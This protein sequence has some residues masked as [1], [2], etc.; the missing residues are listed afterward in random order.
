MKKRM[1]AVVLALCLC[2]SSQSVVYAWQEDT[3]QQGDVLAVESTS[4]LVTRD[5]TIPAPTEVYE[6]MIALKD[7]DG[8]KEGTAWTNDEPYSDSKGY[9]HWKGG[10]LDGKNISAVGCVAFA[11]ILSDEAFGSLPARMYAAGAFKFE[12]IKVGDILRVN[13]DAHT[14]IVL[15]VSEAGVVV[16]EGNISTGDHKGKVH[17]GRAIS[18]E[19]VLSNTSH[20]ITR[21]PE[22]Y[23]PPNDP[24]AN[25]SIAA[26]TLDG[27]LAWN[28]T[29]AGTLTISGKGAMPD[30]SSTEEQP[31]NNNSGKI[32]KVVIGDGVT[33]IGSCAF[34]NCGILSVAISPS[35]STIGNSAF[36]SSSI[37]SVTIPSSVKTIGDSAF[38]ECKNL[39]SVTVSEGVETIAQ[40]AFR[41]CASLTSIALPASIG[42]VGAATF[43]QCQA[44][45][46]VTFAPGSKQVKLGDNMFT[47][48]YYLMGVTLPKSIDCIGEGMF[49]NCL[50]L[51]GVEIPQ[52]AESIGASAFASCSGLTAVIIPDSVTTIGI[53]AFSSCPLTDI[54]FTGTE[55][56]W[57]SI[58]KLGDTVAAVSKATIHYN[59]TPPTK[60]DPDD[61]DNPGNGVSISEATVTLSQTSYTYD[62]KAKTPSVTVKLDGK[63][64]VLN[65]D[66]TISYSNNIQVGTATVTITGKG[67]YTGSKTASFTITKAPEDTQKADISKA[68]LALD[69]TSYTYDGKAKTPSV[70]VKLDGK[71]LV[72]NTDYTVSYSNNIQVGTATVTITGKGNY[73]G[74]K[75]A[76]FTITKAPNPNP[77]PSITCNKTLYKVAYGTKPFKINASSKSKM[78]F[79]SSK[80]KIA[81]VN[82]NTGKVTIK[83]T[84]VATITIKAGKVSKKVT[85][86]V[87]PKKQS[88]KSVKVVK[89]KKLT[90]KWAKDK[91]A[92]GYQVQISTDKKFKKNMKSKNL[93]KTSYT[94]TKLKT[95][96][97][98][99][100]RM[101]SYKKSGKETLYGTWSKV[102]LSSKIKK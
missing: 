24:E 26:G 72:L 90:V 41:A 59:Y 52:G 66:Y 55:A 88:V 40:N 89:G 38:R 73:T 29:K 28:L 74:S 86:K 36:R 33:S 7:R 32:R 64:L 1:L 82:K 91:M 71:T 19:E 67:N 45:T 100:V 77:T 14:V 5:S 25:V 87:S 96:K 44:L 102:K 76:S 92:S 83:N 75:T 35:V 10:T 42:E 46:S 63:T 11:F 51:P 48:C 16:A 27:G 97:K 13:N 50:M 98:Y 22:G 49:Q 85:V 69:K 94:F 39:S 23:I 62:G 58:R 31:W 47:Q 34:W 101:R 15:E 68:T 81:A 56:Q 99:Y 93:A 70:T 65:T 20:Y 37:I 30:F 3:L 4:Q 60:P 80:P 17:W 9:Y 78:T 57:N 2:I 61:G 6:A 12:D 21:Y 54:Y 8:Y 95:G 53:A 84:G 43:F 79:T 18:K